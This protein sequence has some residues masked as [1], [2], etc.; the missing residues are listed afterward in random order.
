M[1]EDDETRMV[2][3]VLPI[4]ENPDPDTGLEGKKRPIRFFLCAA[5]SNKRGHQL[6]IQRASL[7]RRRHRRRRYPNWITVTLQSK[8]YA[9]RRR[10]RRN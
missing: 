8:I 7:P 1:A 9:G 4:F 10:W 2:G 5:F 3:V 6:P